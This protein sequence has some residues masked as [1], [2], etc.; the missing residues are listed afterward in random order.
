MKLNVA[1]RIY[2]CIALPALVT[3][4]GALVGLRSS[5][6]AAD[7][8]RGTIRRMALAGEMSGT[9]RSELD[10][11]AAT[12]EAIDARASLLLGLIA[13]SGIA[14]AVA[15]SAHLV[16]RIRNPLQRSLQAMAAMRNGDFGVTLD[17]SS[18]DEL[19]ELAAGL[20]TM[21]AA[22]Q[23][24][25]ENLHATG[26]QLG[27]AA[28][29]VAAVTRQQMTATAEVAS[30]VVELGATS[31]QIAATSSELMRTMSGVTSGAE[32]TSE[33]ARAGQSALARM[34]GN[35]QQIIEASSAVNSRLVVLSEK[36]GNI[37]AVV[38]TITKV[39]DQTNLLSLNAAIEAEKAAEH[40]R[41][42][43]VVAT[44]IRRLADQTA[45]ATF[46]IEKIVKEMQSAVSAGVMGMDK[47]VEEVRR[48]ADE[49]STL[50]GRM[51]EIN[52]QVQHL[53]PQFEMVSEGVR[54]QAGGAAQ[55]AEALTQLGDTTQESAS[56]LRQSND[57][58]T[59]LNDVASGIAATVS[60]FR[61]AS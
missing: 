23:H 32:Q 58:V 38:N 19:G 52:A 15:S 9:Q 44:E 53:T 24:L 30:M 46:D 33:L 61:L 36:A 49:V 35:M 7:E 43:A 54:A 11:A 50:A 28:S 21:S 6:R 57:A 31:K 55:I 51:L 39:A 27:S 4:A 37:N 41:G 16:R 48:A 17:H 60:N 1:G 40:G 25:L 12:L 59:V 5:D 45:V 22:M 10:R 20:N 18:R 14:A 8:V 56:S 29:H 26:R 2:C 42:F 3:L 13:L 34:N 47:F